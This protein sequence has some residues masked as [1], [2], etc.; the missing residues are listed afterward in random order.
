[1]C[2]FTVTKEGLFK[3]QSFL[4]I[5]RLIGQMGIA[6]AP[7]L[8][9]VPYQHLRRPGTAYTVESFCNRFSK[10]EHH[11]NRCRRVLLISGKV[12][13]EGSSGGKK[14]SAARN[15][16]HS[17]ILKGSLG[18]LNGQIDKKKLSPRTKNGVAF[19]SSKESPDLPKDITENRRSVRIKNVFLKDYLIKNSRFLVF[20]RILHLFFILNKF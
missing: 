8:Y 6:K 9:N 12:K 11:G 5:H 7:K 4:N 20:I 15:F 17:R 13:K 2:I 1:M 19:V 3:R 16:P 18:T 10:E 14:L